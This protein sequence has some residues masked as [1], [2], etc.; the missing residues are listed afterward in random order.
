MHS[1]DIVPRMSERKPYITEDAAQ[2]AESF[3]VLLSRNVKNLRGALAKP[4]EE[5]EAQVAVAQAQITE[6]IAEVV[7]FVSDNFEIAEG[8]ERSILDMLVSVLAELPA[9]R[10]ESAMRTLA[11]TM[12][13]EIT[14]S[15]E[16]SETEN[17]EYF[18][19]SAN[20]REVDDDDINI[21]ID[22]IY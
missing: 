3:L 10:A 5:V 20:W 22:V 13:E 7:S 19:D 21:Q 9:E 11:E 2:F 17:H 4:I 16:K 18:E 14:E 8:F 12:P 15:M 1:C 6:D